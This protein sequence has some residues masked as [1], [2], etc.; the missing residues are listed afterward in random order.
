MTSAFSRPA[1][2]M[3]PFPLVTSVNHVGQDRIFRQIVTPVNKVL[4][5]LLPDYRIR[6]I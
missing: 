5:L 1:E 3:W 2:A 4:L 6:L